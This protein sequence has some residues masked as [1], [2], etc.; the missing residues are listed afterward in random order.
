[1][2]G[3]EI[4]MKAIHLRTEYLCD[5]IGIDIT[6]PRFYW[7]CDG[8]VR[9]SAYQIICKRNGETVWNSGRVA[10]SAMSH[11]P[12]EG[13]SLGSRDI[14]TW[15]VKLW[16]ENGTGG[17]I[18]SAWF[19]MGFLRKEDWQAQWITGN[20]KPKKGCRYPADCFRKCFFV[21]KPLE[22]ARL[23]ITAC[24]LYEATINGKRVGEC[25]LA[26]GVTDYRK[27]IQYQT[28]DVTELLQKENVLEVMLADGWYRGSI[29]CFGKTNV[30][31]RQTK[32]LSQLEISYADGSK[33]MV[34]SDGSFSWSNDGPVRF[35]D[36]KDGEIV[37]AAMKPEYRGNAV[38]CEE[39]TVPTASNN[40]YPKEREHFTA[41]EIRTPS[42]KRVLD[43]GQN[44][45][46]YLTFTVKG[47][48]GQ[49]VKLTCGEILDESGEFTQKNMQVSRPAGE[50]G[51]LDELM[52]IT[53]NEGKIRKKMQPTPLQ[54]ITFFCSGKEDEYR[55][56]FT[57]FGFR[58]ALLETEAELKKIE[59][60]AVYS[61]ME[62]TGSFSCSNEK[63]NRLFR[64]T[65]WSM[66]GNH[67]DVPTDC[68]TRERLAWTGDAQVFFNTG[69]YLMD[70]AAFFRKW[71]K[72]MRDGQFKNGKISAV[73]PYNGVSMVYDNT[74][75]SVGWSDAAVLIPFRYWK[76][77]GDKRLLEECYG[78]MR[79]NAM[80]MIRYTGHKDRKQAKAN[81]FNKYVYEKGVQLGEWLEP[82][83]FKDTEN[84]S[85][86][87]MVPQTEVATAYLHYTMEHMVQAAKELG[88]AEDAKIFQEYADGAKKAYAFLFLQKGAPDTDRQA[89]LVRP[90][91][92][93][94]VDE[95]LKADM[96]KRLA[97]A[98]ENR[99]YR[100]GTGFLSTP[101]VLSVLTEGGRADLA[102]KMLE[103][104]L[105]P[106]WLYEVNRGAT[107]LWE[108]WE[109][110]ASHN[111][112]SPGTVCQW[113]FD[114]V[115]GI[116]PDGENRF[117][118]E[119]VPGGSLT[120]A[121]AE[122]RSLYGKIRSKWEKANHEV[123]FIVEIPANCTA[124][125][126]L[127]D[128]RR[129]TVEA[130][131]HIFSVKLENSR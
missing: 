90:I 121:E 5:P 2:F 20:Y 61:D 26:P 43:F 15:S 98:V 12:Y 65:L 114:T 36:L 115:C 77:Y 92:L 56:R 45:A 87:R 39:K 17:E 102:Y 28:Y 10:S 8:G 68:P 103:N 125:V 33:E 116:R 122:Y 50:Y 86:A 48:P 37:N 101:F 80:F 32:L 106:G 35:A 22:R 112:Y 89:K 19:E 76:R 69:A 42:G 49:V 97:E 109:G 123:K 29:G 73:T 40:V 41:K 3:K 131:S 66:K 75:A 44:I 58:Y 11:I 94:L 25:I 93:G 24:G 1:M 72:D 27:R 99:Q 118:I 113:L 105:C 18:E 53:G 91:A 128:G 117:L 38:L 51:K 67:L 64:N 108:D 21:S 110:K 79:D 95:R 47:K 71:L 16:D 70:T 107:T 74:G 54:E 82:E 31:G 46:G 126:V 62:Q 88:K 7:N 84:N 23:Y 100:V 85:G 6:V 124:E 120:E 9:Q 127:P 96:E 130:G 60:I 30:F 34:C 78:M 13:K 52:L 119:P 4:P 81:P 55:S 111:H 83:E 104:E 129:E 59:A 14:V 63:V 57:I